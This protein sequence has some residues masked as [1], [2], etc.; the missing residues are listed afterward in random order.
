MLRLPMDPTSL[1]RSSSTTG[2]PPSGGSRLRVVAAVVW[3]DGRLLMTQRPPGGPLGL[4]WEF[5]GG[6]IEAGESAERALAR[7]VRE[8]LG[9]GA[10]P[11]D[12]LAVESHVYPQG[13]AVEIVFMACQL[14]SF[15]LQR[16]PG[17]HDIR[18]QRIEEIDLTQVLAGDRP[19]LVRLGARPAGEP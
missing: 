16:G 12:T 13:P 15:D 18:W 14:E 6:K 9:V 19:F 17:I 3:R 5:P 1:E 2:T 11:G 10:I 7:E 4:Q 8:E